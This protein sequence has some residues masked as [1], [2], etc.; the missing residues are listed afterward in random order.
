LFGTKKAVSER[1]FSSAIDCM[2]LSGSHVLSG[3]IAAG[4]P[5]KGV[6]VKESI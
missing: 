4:F 2:M 5:P 1:L 6:S 3:I